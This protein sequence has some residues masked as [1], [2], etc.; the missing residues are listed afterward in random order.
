MVFGAMDEINN[1]DLLVVPVGVNYSNPSKVGSTLFYNIGEPIRVADYYEEYKEHPSKAY[2]KFIKV[3]EPKMKELITHIDN[4]EYDQLV[5]WLEQII[6]RDYCKKR[7]LS[8][9]DPEHQYMVSSHVTECVNEAEHGNK[10]T[11]EKLNELCPDY[12]K[13]LK[14]LGVKDWVVNPN[15]NWQINPF[16]LFLRSLVILI[17]LPLVIRGI[18]GNYIPYKLSERFVAKK[19]KNIEFHSSFNLGIGTFLTIFYYILQFVIAYSLAPNIGWPILVVCVSFLTGK[20]VMNF[21]PFIAKTNGLLKAL[22]NKT[23]LNN[24]REQRKEI[25][26]LFGLINKN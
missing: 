15:S 16:H 5:V 19:V 8:Y 17:A 26:E 20:F 14:M 21:Y 22:L 6:G 10:K 2:N 24:L 11:L 9:K 23:A 1:P 25:T 4:P 3:L 13:N 18:L 12:F 7:K